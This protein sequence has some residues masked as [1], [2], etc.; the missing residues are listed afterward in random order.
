MLTA[1]ELEQIPEDQRERVKAQEK[2][3]TAPDDVLRQN[4]AIDDLLATAVAPPKGSRK[5]AAK[6]H[7][8]AEPAKPHT[9]AEPVNPADVTLTEMV[10]LLVQRRQRVQLKFEGIVM[11]FSVFVYI[12]DD[13]TTISLLGWGPDRVEL[14]LEDMASQMLQISLSEV[15]HY[16]VM[17][18]GSCVALGLHGTLITFMVME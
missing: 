6:P 4:R 11:D 8:T 16:Q 14:K 3:F 18:L 7:T 13:R 9:T 17:Y 15:E 1:A 10:Q 12:S 2:A 5:R